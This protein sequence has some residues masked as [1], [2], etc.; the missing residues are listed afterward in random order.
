M[1]LV[2]VGQFDFT[3]WTPDWHLRHSRFVRLRDDKKAQ[4]IVREMAWGL[5]QGQG[6]AIHPAGRARRTRGEIWQIAEM[7]TR[8][9]YSETAPTRSR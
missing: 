9:N 2:L 8:R 4:D 6:F 1:K 7:K 3:E 5:E